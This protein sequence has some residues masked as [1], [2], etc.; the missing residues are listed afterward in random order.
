MRTCPICNGELEEIDEI[1]T[2]ECL[3]CGT[4]YNLLGMKM[5][6]EDEPTE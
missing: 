5:R 3:K 6:R 2:E 4:T 1:G